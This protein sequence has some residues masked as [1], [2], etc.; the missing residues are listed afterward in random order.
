MPALDPLAR[1]GRPSA[2]AQT[3]KPLN[4]RRQGGEGAVAV[5][6]G[7]TANLAARRAFTTNNQSSPA[8]WSTTG[9]GEP[10]DFTATP[11]APWGATRPKFD[12]S[13]GNRAGWPKLLPRGP[14]PVPFPGNPAMPGPVERGEPIVRGGSPSPGMGRGGRAVRANLPA[15]HLTPA[16]RLATLALRP[17]EC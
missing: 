7:A 10:A 2:A 4:Q 17:H 12:Q 11:H 5:P 9:G 8:A 6:T 14:L 13:P 16:P 3:I 1:C 15:G